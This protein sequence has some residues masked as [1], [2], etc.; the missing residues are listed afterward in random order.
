MLEYLGEQEGNTSR[1]KPN[2]RTRGEVP[3]VHNYFNFSESF[4][5]K[6]LEGGKR[7]FFGTKAD[8]LEY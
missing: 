3:V 4:R 8:R 6:T 7:V 2:G 5:N 1:V